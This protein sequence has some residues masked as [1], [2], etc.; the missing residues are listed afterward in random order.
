[1]PIPAIIDQETWD[2]TRRRMAAGLNLSDRNNRHD[3]L[4]SRR[5]Q[6]ECGYRIRITTM[7]RTKTLK[8]GSTPTYTY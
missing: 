8:D 2:A 1:V 3:Y 6:C 5:I 7:Q 4:V